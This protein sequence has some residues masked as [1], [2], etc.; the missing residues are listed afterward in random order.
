MGLASG[1]ALADARALL[2][3]LAVRAAM[4]EADQRGLQRLADWCGRYSPWVAIDG[5]DGVRLDVTGCAHLFGG[6][7]AL[8][9]DLEARLAGFGVDARMA[10]ADALGAAWALA[11]FASTTRAVAPAGTTRQ[12]IA[13]LPVAALRLSSETTDGLNRLGLAKIEDLMRAPPAALAVRFGPTLTSRL[14]QALGQVAEPISPDRPAPYFLC[15]LI[16]PEPIGTDSDIAAAAE[17]LTQDLCHLLAEE[18]KG[19]RR[20]ELTLYLADGGVRRFDVGCSRPS[21]DPDHLLRLF[22]ERLSGLESGFGADVITLA[23]PVVE[24]LPAVQMALRRLRASVD[25]SSRKTIGA[26]ARPSD[27]DLGLLIDRLGN[28]LG[29]HNIA[30]LAPH[31]SYLPERAV[32][33][34]A[35]L[36]PPEGGMWGPDQPRPVQL[37]AAP[38]PVEAVAEVPDGPPILFRWRGRTHRVARADGPERI[39]PEWWRIRAGKG[40]KVRDY[41]RLEDD[42]GARFWVYR[43]G[44]F[45][46]EMPAR[47]YLHGFFA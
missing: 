18:E 1:M 46:P 39:A 14:R 4:L 28:R 45:Q 41:Y 38:E 40:G 47:W 16:F 37:L 6:E 2:P 26:C 13:P 25:T 29:L 10:I 8:L 24:A 44:L 9:A 32:R 34:V 35:P 20:L 5:E 31:E 30:R 17:R 12:A 42:D 19:G 23:A 33:V 43:D 27:A 11:R 3:D 15:R 21:R 36:A 22:S 7:A